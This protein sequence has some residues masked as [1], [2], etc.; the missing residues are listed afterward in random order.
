MQWYD[1]IIMILDTRRST[2]REQEQHHRRVNEKNMNLKVWSNIINN[3]NPSDENE[4]PWEVSNRFEP[5]EIVLFFR[6]MLSC[7]FFVFFSSFSPIEWRTEEH[8]S[9][10]SSIYGRE[11]KTEPEYEWVCWEQKSLDR[12]FSRNERNIR[13]HGSRQKILIPKYLSFESRVESWDPF[14]NVR[15]LE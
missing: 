2:F 10:E 11:K 5:F 4:I 6:S 13:F 15:A 9:N 14:K 7:F 3:I 12:F 1:V 8:R